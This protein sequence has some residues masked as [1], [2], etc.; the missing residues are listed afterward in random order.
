MKLIRETNR[1]DKATGKT[2]YKWRVTLPDEDV[3]AL[4][5]QPGDDLEAKVRGDSLTL[6]KAKP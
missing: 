3:T 4:G 2:Y 1:T 5:W 6:R